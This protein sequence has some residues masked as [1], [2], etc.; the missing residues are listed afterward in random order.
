MFYVLTIQRHF[1]LKQGFTIVIVLHTQYFNF[2]IYSMVVNQSK[3]SIYFIQIAN[4][5]I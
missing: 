2:K 5:I 1:F 3:V 4:A